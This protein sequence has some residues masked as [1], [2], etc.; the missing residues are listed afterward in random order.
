MTDALADAV[1]SASDVAVTVTTFDFGA[2]AG[3]KVQ[4]AVGDLSTCVA[5]ASRTGQAQIPRCSR[6][7]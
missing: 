2:V 4:T 1:R 6:F 3:A 5:T 7:R